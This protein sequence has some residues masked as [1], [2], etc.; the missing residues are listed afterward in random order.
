MGALGEPADGEFG[1]FGGFLQAARRAL[2]LPREPHPAHCRAEHAHGANAGAADLAFVDEYVED[3]H[4]SQP[5]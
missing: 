3:G 2:R 4:G 1:P 5:F